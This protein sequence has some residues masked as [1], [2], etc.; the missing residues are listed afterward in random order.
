ML[1]YVLPS[2]ILIIAKPDISSMNGD[3]TLI[4]FCSLGL[5]TMHSFG[6]MARD[7]FRNLKQLSCEFITPSNM[8][9]V[10]IP[11]TR[12]TYS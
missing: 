8:N 4:K 11:K 1:L 10:L 7:L 6:K 12:L 3:S 5:K 9:T 2:K